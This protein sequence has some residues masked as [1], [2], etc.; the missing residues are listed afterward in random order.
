M[1]CRAC[2]TQLPQGA[3]NCPQCGA[4]ASYYYSTTEAGP[5]DPTVVSS[6][7]PVVQPPPP[8]T[9]YGSPPYQSPY[10]PY[11]IAPIAPPPPS[12]S[13]PGKRI[14]LIVGIVLLVL[15][16]IGGGVLAWLRFSTAA[17]SF[18]A[19]GTF[20]ISNT[21]TTSTQQAGQN[22]LYNLTQQGVDDGDLTGSFTDEETS[23]S[24]PD[25]T[26]TFS[27][28]ATCTCTVAGK[29]GTLMY[30]FTGTSAADGSFKGQ[31]FDFQG[32]GDLA[33][34]HG[35]GTFQGQGSNG[36]YQGIYSDQLHFDG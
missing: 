18:T 21:T 3:A 27:G 5:D 23:T 9:V 6:P 25:N 28:R 13:R 17:A 31:V 35:Q 16:L 26:S 8:P 7:D 15:L 4:A 14:G 24:H 34:L 29:S 36:T 12:P 20:T 1:N 30:S 19:N 10:E 11:N 32:T 22:T 33:N 2:G